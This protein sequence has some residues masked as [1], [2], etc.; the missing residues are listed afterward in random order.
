[1]S[2]R[3]DDPSGEGTRA[4]WGGPVRAYADYSEFGREVAIHFGTTASAGR[5]A[6]AFE[7]SAG[8]I[9]YRELEPH[10]E[11]VA[12]EPVLRLNPSEG[13]A[14]YEALHRIYGK[15]EVRYDD[16]EFLRSVYER[17]AGRVDRLLFPPP[18]IDSGLGPERYPH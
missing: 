5:Q 1:M 4:P 17:E 2:V 18:V 16:A 6:L 10:E 11:G 12:T 15:P 9:A 3:R 14:L 7:I 8:H 13:E